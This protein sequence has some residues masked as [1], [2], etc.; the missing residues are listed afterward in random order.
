MSFFKLNLFYESRFVFN[1]QNINKLKLL[2]QNISNS[3][4][5][6]LSLQSSLYQFIYL[7]LFPIDTILHFIYYI[8]KNLKIFLL[9]GLVLNDRLADKIKLNLH[10]KLLL[11]N[12]S[13]YLY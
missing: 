6:I 4:W 13:K 8:D 12:L 1:I 10:I 11:V 2:I 3:C 7:L 9:I 5:P